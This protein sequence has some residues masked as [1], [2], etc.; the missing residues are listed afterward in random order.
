ML[1]I[2][3][4]GLIVLLI[5]SLRDP[6]KSAKKADRVQLNAAALLEELKK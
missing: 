1:E 3:I 5:I 4:A 2:I 6:A